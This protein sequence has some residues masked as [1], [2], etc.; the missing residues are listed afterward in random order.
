MFQKIKNIIAFFRGYLLAINSK[1]MSRKRI[2]KLQ[3]K[4]FNVFRQKVLVN[5]KYYSQ[6][7]Q[8]V[9]T[10]YPII[11]KTIHM[12]NFDVINTANLRKHE[13]LDIAI[14]SEFDRNFTPKYMG[15]SVGL[16]SGTS[17]S[18][19]LFVVSEQ[20]RSEWVG[21]IIGK[22]L[23]LAIKKHRIAF[24]LRAN[25]NLYQSA[26]GLVI[27]FKFFDLIDGIEA[28]INELNSYS[29]SILI[30]PASVLRRIAESQTT[31]LPRRVISVAEV[32]EKEDREI[33][34]QR[35]CVHVE[36]IYQCTEG[37]LGSTCSFGNIHLNED[38]YIIEKQ[39]L[40]KSTG[41]FSPIV[42]DL[43]R[44]TQPIIRYLLDDVLIEESSPCQCGSAMIRIKSIEGRCDDVLQ[45]KGI[46]GGNID[47]FSD[48]I[49]NTII[50]SS[51]SIKH[52]RV[53]QINKS[54]IIVEIF[55][56][57]P[58]LIN[59]VSKRLKYLWQRLSIIHPCCSFKEMSLQFNVDKQRRVVRMYH[60]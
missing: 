15:F 49:R 56:Y 14:Q 16:S 38:S 40:H 29:P 46:E 23:P 35:F 8:N 51:D 31:I 60:G 26:N 48:Y 43:R 6:Y 12:G 2:E 5:S 34:E 45:F 52:Y 47:V 20:E 37:F 42:T 21:Y 19:G 55:P 39:W 17:G 53:I 41:R 13:A 1:K 25:N 11:N 10:E 7:S 59:A 27:T 44:T 36:Q 9:L 50:S 58:E 4:K 57:T 24:F 22:M 54:E 28:N 18:R 32:L 3:V 30:A 33:I